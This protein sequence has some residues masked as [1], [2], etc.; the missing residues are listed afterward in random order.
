MYSNSV[1]FTKFNFFQ[2]P[3]IALCKD[4]VQCSA[5]VTAAAA[6]WALLTQQIVHFR[7]LSFHSNNDFLRFIQL[8][9]IADSVDIERMVVKKCR[10][11]HELTTQC[12]SQMM[13]RVFCIFSHKSLVQ[14]TPASSRQLNQLRWYFATA[15]NLKFWQPSYQLTIWHWYTLIFFCNSYKQTHVFFG[16]C[17]FLWFVS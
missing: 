10:M 13:S 8:M 7:L 5:T 6:I 9:Y 4:S 15:S 14:K 2:V 17:N 3:K 11:D 16:L 1:K 12:K